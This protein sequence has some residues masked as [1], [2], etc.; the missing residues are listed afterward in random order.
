MDYQSQFDQTL[1]LIY[2]S[3]LAPQRLRDALS[4]LIAALDGDTCHLVGWDRETNI[5]SVNVLIGIREDETLPHYFSH[6]CHIDPRVELALTLAPGQTFACHEHFDARFVARSEFH[7][8][9]LLPRAAVHYLLGTGDLAV[10]RQ[11]VTLIG[12]HRYIGH[13]PFE[14]SNAGLLGRF[15][16]H[17]RRALQMSQQV[18]GDHDAKAVS[19]SALDASSLAALALSSSG[20]ILWTNRRGEALLR[21][22][23]QLCQRFGALHATDANHDV[24]LKKAMRNTGATGRPGNLNVGDSGE[25]CCVTL[26]ATRER[27][28]LAPQSGRA[29][30]LAL[31]T[32]AAGQR[33]A[34]ARQLMDL[35]GLSPAEARVVRALAHG[36]SIDDYAAQE[37]LKRSTV[38]TQLLSA[39]AKTGTKSQKDIVRLVL[40][41]PAIRA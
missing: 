26:L 10:D 40:S 12:F 34:S 32:T 1:N 3:A 18:R 30:I 11:T 33:V 41:L 15:L 17:L 6:Y 16:P 2:E 20:A 28:P 38:K 37:G 39:L 35:F 5:P 4:G 8:D 9:Y 25:H 23:K 24:A 13:A 27:N 21:E 22:G 31:V 29:E 14:P 19:E 7:Q 36:E